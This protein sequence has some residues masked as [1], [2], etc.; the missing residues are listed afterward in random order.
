MP[1]PFPIFIY[2]VYRRPCFGQCRQK[3]IE[4]ITLEIKKKL[5]GKEKKGISNLYMCISQIRT[6]NTRSPRSAEGSTLPVSYI[7]PEAI[8]RMAA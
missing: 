1:P 2:S 3:N 8:A 7:A 5:E 6:S 4:V